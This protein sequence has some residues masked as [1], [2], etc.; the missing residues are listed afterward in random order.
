MSVQSVIKD[1]LGNV[2]DNL[3]KA[4][5]VTGVPYQWFQGVLKN[6]KRIQGVIDNLEKVRKVLKL[7]PGQMWE[8]LCRK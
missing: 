4:G 6:G 3:T 7:S 5:Q 2:G 1:L 8:R